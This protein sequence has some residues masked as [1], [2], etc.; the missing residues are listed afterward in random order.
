MI[1][2]GLALGSG[3]ARGLAH[4]GVLAVLEEEGL[5]PYCI[6]GTSMGAI[7]G[8]LYCE[9]GDTKR[10]AERLAIYTEDAEFKRCW[11]PFV[12]DDEQVARG[13]LSE[14][15]RS[16]QRRILSFKTFTTPA[17]QKA[18]LLL[19]PL[20]K[21]FEVESIEDLQIPFACV[22]MDLISGEPRFFYQ[23][24]LVSAIYA[25][26]A[27]P[28]VFPPLPLGGQLLIDGGGPYRVPIGLARRLG[29]EFIL[30]IDIP[31]FSPDRDEFKTGLDVMMRS[32]TI[33]RQRLNHIVLKEADFVVRPEV[34]HFHWANFG[35]VE[36][37][38][39]AG[40]EAMRAALPR[41]RKRLRKHEGLGF[42]LKRG[43]VRLW[44]SDEE[45]SLTPRSGT[46]G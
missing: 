23:G 36:R 1:K 29:G 46:R 39:E 22:A 5:R 3:G 32:D 31:S 27:I 20:R 28:G 21:L 9:L 38:Q 15:R 33:A 6:S 34:G 17:Q 18:E 40:A 11:E 19:E 2:L 25:S 26:G 12:E 13:R 41:L 10:L 4:Q 16:I 35:A 14:F 44:G 8:A 45:P 24:F 7:I 30:A 42:K 37:I 43:I